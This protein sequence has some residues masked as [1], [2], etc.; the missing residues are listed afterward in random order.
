M[1]ESI[2]KT[3]SIVYEVCFGAVFKMTVE[4]KKVVALS[5]RDRRGHWCDARE[6]ED[7]TNVY[8]DLGADAFAITHVISRDDVVKISEMFR[9]AL[10]G[11]GDTATIAMAIRQKKLGEVLEKAFQ[12][13]LE[14]GGPILNHNDGS[15]TYIWPDDLTAQY[16][17]KDIA[18]LRKAYAYEMMEGADADRK[19]II[20]EAIDRFNKFLDKIEPEDELYWFEHYETL[21]DRIGYV[22]IRQGRAVCAHLVLMS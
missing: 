16:S 12:D 22:I 3:P 2:T 21:A 17:L 14:K 9:A 19:P 4:G 18:A 11:D 15:K 6:I 1:E 20:E 8:S 7:H 10:I 5:K 13:W